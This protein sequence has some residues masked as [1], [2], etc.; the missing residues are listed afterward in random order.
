M[1]LLRS[2]RNEQLD[3]LLRQTD[4]CLRTLAT[5]LAPTLQRLERRKADQALPEMGESSE[6][7][8]LE[9]AALPKPPV[10]GIASLAESTHLW[11]ELSERIPADIAEQPS[12]LVGAKEGLGVPWCLQS[13]G[14]SLSLHG[15]R[16]LS[17][18]AA[19]STPT[20]FTGCAGWWACA[21]PA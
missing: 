3:G 7:S 21:A 15:P 13:T 5:R 19:R 12:T 11:N 8:T 18:Q 20:S 1:Q 6:G 9:A 14:D 17:F 4:D 10:A 2:T 16:F